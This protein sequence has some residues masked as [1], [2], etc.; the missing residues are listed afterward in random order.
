MV[1]HQTSVIF[2][3]DGIEPLLKV[4]INSDKVVSPLAGPITNTVQ[5]FIHRSTETVMNISVI[6]KET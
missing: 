4:V 1:A 6:H 2:R 3:L 5:E